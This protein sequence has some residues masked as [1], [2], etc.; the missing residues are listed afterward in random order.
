LLDQSNDIGEAVLCT[1]CF[2]LG[3]LYF[4]SGLIDLEKQLNQSAKPTTSP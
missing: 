4:V 3:A 2:V 1:W